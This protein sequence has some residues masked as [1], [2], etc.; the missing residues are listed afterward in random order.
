MSDG[1][2]ILTQ[3]A[4][5]D[6][7]ARSEYLLV[8]N[9]PERYG[10]YYFHARDTT[11]FLSNCLASVDITQTY[12]ARFYSY[13]KKHHL[14]AILST[15]RLHKV[16]AFM[17][18]R[19]VLEAGAWAA[20]AI[21][22]PKQDDFVDF[23]GPHGMIR[24]TR[25]HSDRRNVWLNEH[26]SGASAYIKTQKNAINDAIAHAGPVYAE[27][28]FDIDETARTFKLPYW[29]DEDIFHIRSDLW[30][31]AAVGIQLMDL[32]YHAK[33]KCDGRIEFASDFGDRIS[34]LHQQ[35]LCLQHEMQQSTRYQEIEA[36]ERESRK[37]TEA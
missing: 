34:S 25:K 27:K 6:Q 10:M 22:N 13:A 2:D 24:T 32:F 8:L 9:A 37:P 7:I 15:V 36:R 16:Q 23:A 26:F 5:L 12:F 29:D 3:S 19:H 31:I 11:L 33:L 17:N 1:A 20:Y 18:L 30:V 14:L 21:A 35:H 28:V 4:T